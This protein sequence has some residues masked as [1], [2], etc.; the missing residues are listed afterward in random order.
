MP[1]DPTWL[2]R[3]LEAAVASA[4]DPGLAL[5]KSWRGVRSAPT[6]LLAVGKAAIPMARVARQLLGNSLT[7]T[8]VV[9]PGV[10]ATLSGCDVLTADHPY[11]TDRSLAAGIAVERFVR[12]VPANEEL[13]V[14][15]SG[16]GSAMV[17]LPH[18]GLEL[19]DIAELTRAAQ[20][21]GASIDDLNLL[22]RHCERVKGGALASLC[23]AATIRVY[24]LSDVIGDDLATI[25]SGPFA[26]DP[27]THADAAHVL[28][29]LGLDHLSP[30]VASFLAAGK[31][32]E[33]LKSARPG[34]DHVIVASNRMIGEAV[35]REA[36]EHAQGVTVDHGVT[37]EAAVVGR[38]LAARFAADPRHAWVVAG[39]YTVTVGA[40]EGVGGPTQEMALAAAAELGGRGGWVLWAYST[41]G[42]DG[43]S[44]ACGVIATDQTMRAAA[45]AGLNARHA[46]LAHDSGGFW[47][48]CGGA[49]P[50]RE[51]GTNL[52]HV[53]LLMA[54]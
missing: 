8:L 49:I 1:I 22:R 14:L 11:P 44:E 21:A 12:E 46:L 28:A 31:H 7:R 29:R 32:S 15:L 33:T 25:A 13:V 40:S 5:E 23:P 24:V 52:N 6:R 26:P 2:C 37:G 41:D 10:D 19:S 50:R 30:R 43:P 17:C 4:G 3:R 9:A 45:A 16:G 48:G 51:T 34:V 27:T 53:A 36:A 38:G 20:L 54:L 39:E 47:A 42:R 35:A 18:D